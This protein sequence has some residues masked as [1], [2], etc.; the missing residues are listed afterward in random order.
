MAGSLLMLGKLVYSRFQRLMWFKRLRAACLKPNEEHDPFLIGSTLTGKI[1]ATADIDLH[2]YSDDYEEIQERLIAHGY[3]DVDEEII[4]NL[5][6]DFVHLKW[7]EREYPVEITVYPWS[8][9]DLVLMSSI[10]QKPM[11]RAPIQQVRRL[12][13][14]T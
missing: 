4:Q 5:K 7:Y 9:R 14:E 1:R 8:W 11:K 2:A 12:L 10:T 13:L 3:E 6:G